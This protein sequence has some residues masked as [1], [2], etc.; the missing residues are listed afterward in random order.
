MV[1]INKISGAT[2]EEIYRK[3]SEA[4]RREGFIPSISIKSGKSLNY[5]LRIDTSMLGHRISPY[6]GRRGNILGWDDWVKANNLV[7]DVLDGMNVSANVFSL[8]GKFRIREGKRRFTE[9]DWE[10]LKYENIGSMMSP[11]Q[12]GEAWAPE[13]YQT[14]L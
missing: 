13:S 3:L 2:P 8:A 12:R 14:K 4:F 9:D 11:V 7:N 1:T 10:G 5:T 6:T